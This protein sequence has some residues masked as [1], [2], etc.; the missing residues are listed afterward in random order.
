MTTLTAGEKIAHWS[1]D[2]M[3]LGL[4]ASLVLIALL[5]IAV[6][7]WGATALVAGHLPIMRDICRALIALVFV[8]LGLTFA[9]MWWNATL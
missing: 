3:T 2:V 9:A 6:L 7:I 1:F 5:A 4:L 8:D